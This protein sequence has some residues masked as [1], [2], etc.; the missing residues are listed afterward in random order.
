MKLTFDRATLVKALARL[1]RVIERKT[2]IPVLGQVRLEAA[3]TRLTITGTDLDIHYRS[4]IDA[5]IATP[6][7]T[8]INAHLLYDIARKISDGAQIT[9][10]ETGAG[11]MSLRSGRARFSLA[12][13]PAIDFPDYPKLEPVCSF[14]LASK[15][16]RA[17]V[18]QVAFAMSTE[19]TRYY[20]NGIFWHRHETDEGPMLRAVATDGH[21]LGRFEMLAP[22]ID[23]TM[24]GIIIPR[25]AVAELTAL[26]DE[27]DGEISIEITDRL[28]KAMA[29][30]IE[31]VS[32]LVDGTF[33]DYQRVIPKENSKIAKVE[34]TGFMAAA[35]RVATISSERGRSVKLGFSAEAIDLDVT[36]PDHG[37]ANEQIEATYDGPPLEIGFNARYLHEVLSELDGAA[38]RIE[39]A[40]PG[41]PTLF[42]TSDALL[43]VLM[44]MRV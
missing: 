5:D 22:A 18:K 34:R 15:D 11:H 25:K 30:R 38:V 43:V 40:D 35:D 3:E 44:P 28:I 26:A 19:E 14:N 23:G 31:I 37:N 7:S 4:A 42:S 41:S 39:L 12:T 8:T 20:L 36:S 17:M 16:L 21:R 13:L 27:I 9:L 24:P 2:T 1:S 29:G 32:K 6:G 33:P 10:E